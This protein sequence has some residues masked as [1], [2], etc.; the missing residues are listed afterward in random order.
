MHYND[1]GQSGLHFEMPQVP[2]QVH[3]SVR[4]HDQVMYMHRQSL[5]PLAQ[6][7]GNNV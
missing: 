5:D 4:I 6:H 1:A 3:Q 7:V 2:C